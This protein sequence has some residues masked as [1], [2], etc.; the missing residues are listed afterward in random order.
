M[1]KIFDIGSNTG[2]FCKAYKD[3]YPD[4][5]IICVEPAY[6][7]I[8]SSFDTTY[9]EFPDIKVLQYACSD[10]C[11][12]KIDFYYNEIFHTIST[13]S[14]DWKENSRFNNPKIYNNKWVK[15][16]VRTVTIDFLLQK[17]GTPDYIK[18]DAEGY[19]LTV[20]KGLTK[21]V[22]FVGIEWA[23]ELK[24]DIIGCV[25]RLKLLKFTKFA[26]QE[27]DDYLDL[28]GKKDYIDYNTIRDII[29]KELDSNRKERWGMIYSS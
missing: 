15:R 9:A 26:L 12:E 11:N 8:I 25:D 4:S 27:T 17:F 16:Q 22:P 14:K 28:P 20:L 10:K 1:K 6:D 13:C 3:K 5:E 7:T 19:E 29:V 23:E 21:K 18:I 24:T 2:S